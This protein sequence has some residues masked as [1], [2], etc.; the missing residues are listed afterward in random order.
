MP[1]YISLIRWTEQGARNAKDALSR[2]EQ[3][4]AAVEKAGGRIVGAWWMMGAYD[5]VIV[6]EFPDD[7]TVSAVVIGAGMAGNTRSETMRAFT[8]EEM[9][10]IL[11]KLP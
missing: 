9:Q 1:T 7:E 3:T 10:R 2:R 6:T 11:Q 8:A 5:A 4:L